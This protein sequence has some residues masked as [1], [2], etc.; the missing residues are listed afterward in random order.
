MEERYLKI[1]D[2]QNTSLSA[3][4]Y[5]E[6]QALKELNLLRGKIEAL[7]AL[8]ETEYDN[9]PTTFLSKLF[10]WDQEDKKNA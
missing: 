2:D 3:S 4:H 8:A 5:R 1:I 6:E 10:G 7:K 9:I